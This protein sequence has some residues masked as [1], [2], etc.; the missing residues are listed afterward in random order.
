M[1][2]AG[3]SSRRAL[4]N[5]SAD[6]LGA[7]IKILSRWEVH[8]NDFNKTPAPSVPPSRQVPFFPRLSRVLGRTHPIRGDPPLEAKL[9]PGLHLKGLNGPWGSLGASPLATE[10][11][12]QKSPNSRSLARDA[13]RSFG[14]SVRTVHGGGPQA[15]EF[16]FPLVT[17]DVS[18]QH[19]F[20]SNE[21][22]PAPCVRAHGARRRPAHG[23]THAALRRHIGSHRAL[24]CLFS[25]LVTSV[26]HG[27]NPA[28]HGPGR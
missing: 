4:I 6:N 11:R 2:V 8:R 25:L 18:P 7:A 23:R 26:S 13:E 24:G 28:P 10:G 22:K 20:S 9:Q 5:V 12:R 19:K 21:T 3:G 1:A 14:W 17:N 27:S 15:S 16:C